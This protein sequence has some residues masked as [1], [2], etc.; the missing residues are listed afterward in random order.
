M[1]D[2]VCVKGEIMVS[3]IHVEWMTKVP[4]NDSG[5]CDYDKAEWAFKVFDGESLKQARM[6][7]RVKANR[8]PWR[9]VWIYRYSAESENAPDWMWEQ[10]Y[11][12]DEIIEGL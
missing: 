7:A 11:S 8:N 4:I 6:F 10:D 9:Q 12:A 3:K 5:D 2:H 1:N